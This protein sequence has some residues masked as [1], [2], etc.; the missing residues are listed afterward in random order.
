MSNLVDP[1]DWNPAIATSYHRI[2][3]DYD[4][5]SRLARL[6]G[7]DLLGNGEGESPAATIA[8]V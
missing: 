1:V 4:E 2:S 3:Y 8:C 7:F 5:M 6:A